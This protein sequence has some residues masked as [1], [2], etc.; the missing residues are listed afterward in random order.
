MADEEWRTMFGFH[1]YD[2]S[3]YGNVRNNRTMKLLKPRPLPSGY[4]RV[5][6]YQDKV[7]YEYYI[8]RLVAELFLDNAE[9]K[10]CVDHIDHD[11]KNNRVGNLR[12][13]TN[14]ENAMNIQKTRNNMSSNYKGVYFFKLRN[15][16][17]AHIVINGKGTHL[18]L[19]ASEKDAAEAYN[20][21]AVQNFGA[22]K[23]LNVLE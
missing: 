23:L 20:T 4:V 11:V 10:R 7:R 22:H 21:A 13:V 15:K 9:N 1:N 18:G 3:S 17:R 19:F 14:T 5:H 12:W 8:H 2:V 16:W 6:V